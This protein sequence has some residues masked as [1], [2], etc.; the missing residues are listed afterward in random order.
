MQPNLLSL[1][2]PI[3]PLGLGW[4]GSCAINTFFILPSQALLSH[5]ALR[6]ECS[7]GGC[8][9]GEHLTLLPEIKSRQEKA[10]LGV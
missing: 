5:S 7:W 9:P 1:G 8:D 3:T 6:G 4:K 10:I 2:L